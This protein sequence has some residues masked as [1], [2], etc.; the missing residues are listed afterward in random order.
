MES[1]WFSLVSSPMMRVPCVPTLTTLSGSAML[2][3]SHRLT[4]YLAVVA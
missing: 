1:I 3:S 2:L 4:P